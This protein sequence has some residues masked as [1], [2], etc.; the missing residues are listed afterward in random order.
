ML[1]AMVT[2]LPSS[3]AAL[4]QTRAERRRQTLPSPDSE[5]S[6]PSCSGYGSSSDYNQLPTSPHYDPAPTPDTVKPE[7]QSQPEPRLKSILKKR[8]A[9]TETPAP[10]AEQFAAKRPKRNVPLINYAEKTLEQ[11]TAEDERDQ[12]RSDLAKLQNEYDD[13]KIASIDCRDRML[14]E[15]ADRFQQ[16]LNQLQTEHERQLQ[17][18]LQL[19]K[20]EH[21]EHTRNLQKAHK[22]T[23]A[24]NAKRFTDNL[25]AQ[26]K[27]LENQLKEAH[28]AHR[29]E[30]S[31]TV[32][33]HATLYEGRANEIT[34]LQEQ[35]RNQVTEH[36]NQI[37]AQAAA[38]A[39]ALEARDAQNEQLLAVAEAERAAAR[40]AAIQA[41]TREEELRRQIDEHRQAATQANIQLGEEQHRVHCRDVHIEEQNQELATTIEQRN[42]ARQNMHEMSE[43]IGDLEEQADLRNDALTRLRRL[44]G[45][46]QRRLQN[47]PVPNQQIQPNQ[48]GQIQPDILIE[49]E[50]IVELN[51]EGEI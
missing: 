42:H 36:E 15:Q 34:R 20:A 38:H 7:P 45:Q 22:E 5:E 48:P 18:R 29:Q 19:Q 14:R 21:D 3:A 23:I 10:A 12:A 27:K 46:L 47:H 11:L 28:Q 33:R 51:E 6:R 44:V 31:E 17:H 39:A 32:N 26:R 1:S 2:R 30:F 25:E 24:Y 37:Q 50:E 9:S 49:D 43:Q 16:Q 8:P 4:T 41:E 13:F 40:R 35:L